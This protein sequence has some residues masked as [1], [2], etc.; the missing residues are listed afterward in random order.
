M[1]EQLMEV[2]LGLIREVKSDIKDVSDKLD[3]I[4]DERRVEAQHNGDISARVKALEGQMPRDARTRMDTLERKHRAVAGVAA[5]LPE[6]QPPT[7]DPGGLLQLYAANLLK[8]GKTPDA[9]W[10]SFRAVVIAT[11][12]DALLSL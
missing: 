4:A 6:G 7:Q 12:K 1:G 9:S 2:A 3:K 5:W 10:E 11:S 8:W